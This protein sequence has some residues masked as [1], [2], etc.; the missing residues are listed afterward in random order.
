[1]D[2]WV[3]VFETDQPYL[4]EMVK[5]ILCENNIDAVLLSH[6]DASYPMLGS[7]RIMVAPSDREK[8]DEIIKTIERE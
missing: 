4:A 6:K 8:A 5:D 7:I 2:N 3:T 1:M